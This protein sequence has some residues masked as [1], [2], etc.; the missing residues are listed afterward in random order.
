MNPKQPSADL[1]IDF[2]GYKD[3]SEIDG[4]GNYQDG[5]ES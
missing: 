4:P 1:V 3:Q 2:T 5:V